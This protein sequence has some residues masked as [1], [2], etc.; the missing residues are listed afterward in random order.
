VQRFRADVGEP[1]TE[2]VREARLAF[3]TALAT[4]GT[5]PRARGWDS[6]RVRGPV[7]AGG[8]AA[9]AGTMV[10]VGVPVLTGAEDPG[11]GVPSGGPGVDLA[12]PNA[13]AAALTQA[14]DALA[15][16]PEQPAIQPGQYWYQAEVEYQGAVPVDTDTGPSIPPATTST[17]EI[18]VASDGS[19]ARIRTEGRSDGGDIDTTD[20]GPVGPG[21]DG[22]AAWEAERYQELLALPRDAAALH[23]YLMAS[24]E[25]TARSAAEEGAGS[26]HEGYAFQAFLELVTDPSTP[27]GLREA[28]Y[29]AAAL[30]PGVE[31]VG[32][33]EDHLGR[34]GTAVTFVENAD[35]SF[36]GDRE[37]LI[38]DPA[39]GDL[40]G[41][42]WTFADGTV[43]SASAI[44][45]SGIVDSTDDV[46]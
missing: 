15:A 37:E 41:T 30:I 39:T 19:V 23:G 40:L 45:T 7:L 28:L 29:R 32:E 9:L 2:R 31:L 27:A 8:A 22:A 43:A 12:V 3:R 10:L 11:G 13:A 36:P 21:D 6:W 18:W 33:V 26:S 25:D 17:Y 1:G 35:G 46:P 38:F 14:A 20:F 24:T 34:T 4:S 16:Q 42:R 44:T 5:R